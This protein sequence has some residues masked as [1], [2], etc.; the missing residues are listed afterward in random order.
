MTAA[1]IPHPEA[2]QAVFDYVTTLHLALP[3]PLR[4]ALF[5]A[6]NRHHTGADSLEDGVKVPAALGEAYRNVNGGWDV[7]VRVTVMA[8]GTQRL[9]VVKEGDVS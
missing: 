4:N 8:D 6:L 3:M 7:M 9:E 5:A 2:P 1:A